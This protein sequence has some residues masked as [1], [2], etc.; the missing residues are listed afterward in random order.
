MALYLKYLQILLKS[1]LQYRLSFGLLVLGQFIIPFS[2]FAGIYFLFA[3]FGTLQGWTFYEVALGFAVIHMAFAITQC[4]VRGFDQFPQLV[5]SGDFDRMM[6]RPPSLL[7]Q[8]FASRF[9]FIKIGRLLQSLA[10]LIWAIS[11]LPAIWGFLKIMTLGLMLASGVCLFA[12]LYILTA[13]LSF[14][15][16]QGLDLVDVFA[17]GGREMAQYPQHIYQRWVQRF[18]TFVIPFGCINYL[19]LLFLLDKMEG[20]PWPYVLSP[21]YSLLFLGPCLGIWRI[22]VRRYLSSG[23]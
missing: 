18:F 19:P 2:F 23:S 15:T 14:W 4:F 10:V 5:N 21:L 11:E 22:G 8:V 20:N 13:A 9:E 3:R 17:N 1:Q 6:L 7:L 16:I 12:S